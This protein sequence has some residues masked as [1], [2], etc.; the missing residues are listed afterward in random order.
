[1]NGSVAVVHGG[2]RSA[3]ACGDDQPGGL[4]VEPV[5]E[6]DLAVLAS[7]E[8]PERVAEERAGR[9]HA[10]ISGLSMTRKSASSK[11]TRQCSSASG[12]GI[13]GG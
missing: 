9:M 13:S 2:G 3:R 10:Q 8:V 12:S 6:T 11:M 7:D 4:T 1:M 5:H